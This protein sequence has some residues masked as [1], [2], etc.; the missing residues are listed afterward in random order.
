MSV[1][2]ATG[3]KFSQLFPQTQSVP[4]HMHE[5]E[6]KECAFEGEGYRVTRQKWCSE[7]QCSL[8]I[9]QQSPNTAKCETGNYSSP[10]DFSLFSPNKKNADLIIK[11]KD[12][13][14]VAHRIEYLFGNST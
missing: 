12:F 6:Q 3:R 9:Q 11:I 2:L 14:I 7:V 1:F 5:V 4:L 8:C 13:I 10:A